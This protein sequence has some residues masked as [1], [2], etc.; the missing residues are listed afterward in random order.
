MRFS[1]QMEFRAWV[2]GWS[3]TTREEVVGVCPSTV[4]LGCSGEVG[5]PLS[6]IRWPLGKSG[7][8]SFYC[9]LALIL[10]RSRPSLRGCKTMSALFI[11]LQDDLFFPTVMLD[12]SKRSFILLWLRK[13]KTSHQ[14]FREWSSCVW[15]SPLLP[16]VTRYVQPE[17]TVSLVWTSYPVRNKRDWVP[18]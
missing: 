4:L 10:L 5:P 3:L 1:V 7:L 2:F 15:A 12:F 11:W 6:T 9:L 16:R 18:V 13:E 8:F 14:N 17:V